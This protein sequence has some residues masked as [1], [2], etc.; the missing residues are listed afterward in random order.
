MADST[1]KRRTPARRTAKPRA[2]APAPIVQRIHDLAWA[3][4]HAKAIELATQALSATAVAVAGRLDLLD[5]RSESFV[6]QGDLARAA[7][8]SDAMLALAERAKSAAF[9]AQARNRLA[10]VQMRSGELR[11]AQAS[12]V[13]ALKFARQ[14]KRV[15]LEAMSLFRLAEAQFRG[16][17]ISAE[18]V[19]NAAHAAQLFEKTGDPIGQGRALWAV[20]T[21]SSDLGR[22]AECQEAAEAAL[23]IGR[24]CG[25]LYGLGNAYN[26]LSYNL[27]DIAA[28]M[29]ALNQ[30]LAS[31][32]AAGYVE[33]QGV[34]NHNLAVQYTTLGQ[35]RRARRLGAKAAELYLQT[36][37]NAGR[38]RFVQAFIELE[39]GHLDAARAFASSSE[40]APE[41]EQ[42]AAFVSYFDGWLD[43]KEGK[44]AQGAGKDQAR[45][46]DAARAE[47]RCI[48]AGNPRFPRRSPARRE[49]SARSAHGDPARHRAA[50]R[51]GFCHADR[52]LVAR[53]RL[54]GPQQGAC[55]QPECGRRARGARNR[56]PTDDRRHRARERRGTAP[57]LPRPCEHAPGDHRGVAQGRAQTPTGRRAASAHLEGEANLREPFERLVDTGLRLNELRST[58]ELHEFL[59]DEA[60]ELSGAERVLLVL[61]GPEGLR[62]AGSLVPRGEDATALLREVTPALAEVRRTRVASLAHTPEG[63]DAIDQRSL[64]IAPLIAQ[65]ELL[66]YLYCDID[67]AFGRFHDADRD[68]LGMLASQAA[69]ALD[70][71][72]WSQGLEQKVAQRTEELQTSKALIEQRAGELAIINSI[73]E[74][75]AAELDFQAIVD[76][77]GDKLRA[78]FHTDDMGIRWVDPKTGLVHY[79]Y[80]YE[81]GVRRS[82]PP[83]PLQPGGT[84]S[85][86]VNTRQPVL[87]R[88]RAEADASGFE[89]I[90]DPSLSSV[91]APIVGSDR[92][93][94]QIALYNYERENAYGESEVRLLC[95]VGASMGVALENAR[96]FDE[97]QRLLKETEQRNAELAVINSIQQGLVA[98]LDLMAII[99]LVGDKLREVFDNGNVTIEWF[100]DQ[101]YVVAPVY[102]YEHGQRLTDV[103]PTELARSER[104]L[105]VVQERVAVAQKAMPEGAKAFPGTTLPKSDVRAPVVAAGRVIALVSLDNFEREDA[106]D[107][108]D[109]RLLTTVCTA[110]GMALQSARLFDETQHLLKETEQRAAELAVIN[111]IQEGMA[112]ELDFQAIIDLVGDKIREVFHTGDIG[113][114]WY[115]AEANVLHAPYDYEHGV[116]LT[117]LQPMKPGPDSIWFK[118]MNSRQ[119]IVTNNPA[120]AA[121]LGTTTIP[122]TDPSLSSVRVPILGGDRVLGSIILEDFARENAYGESEVRLLSTV[123]ASMGVALE[124]ARLFD[125][126]QR[127]FKESE[128]RAAELAIINSVQEGL[129]AQLDF[130][131]IIDL[132]GDKIAEIFAHQGHVDRTARQGERDAGDAVLPRARRALSGRGVPARAGPDRKRD[133]HARA[134][135]HQQRLQGASGQ[136][137]LEADRR[138]SM[139]RTCRRA[140][141]A[142]RSSRATR[143]SA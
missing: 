11:K 1:R 131:S 61:E 111:S 34:A 85:K 87:L 16:K 10:L 76:L 49:G 22:V 113:I 80:E 96:L 112:A 27:P 128:Q 138:H 73:Q 103:P 57:Q 125:E 69:V 75:M 14:S 24:R 84:F 18:A 72:Q 136:L 77:V 51:D 114:R 56:V 116:R 39:M 101:T 140:T 109:V 124:N 45:R 118:L 126:T 50:S 95:T 8:D 142:C 74:G 25:D 100:D 13:A 68:L 42:D 58:R 127:L 135:G 92:V 122:G 102:A 93:C 106:F 30:S 46:Q 48:R 97:T 54:V 139:P 71:A 3:G 121:A 28:N 99:D 91:Y 78:V 98:Q 86:M 90:G 63:V 117:G 44:S 130:Q 65:R 37:A 129:A 133:E 31:F 12:A 60:T 26:C 67:G 134:T 6:A 89:I 35:Y 5:L 15:S 105:R 108:D 132:V 9:E 55:G 119:P 4:Q 107:D 64:V 82:Y 70:N 32:E 53:L 104:N 33:R 88:N 7:A 52:A 21:A 2:G 120:E 36:G 23:A 59:I 94:G 143:R 79:L 110:M 66:G 20:A 40:S 29:K 141:S 123:A 115:D 62:L 137:W 41:T 19:R 83:M 47:E 38:T 81:H 43:F 17:S